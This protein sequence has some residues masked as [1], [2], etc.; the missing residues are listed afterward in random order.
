M[1]FKVILCDSN[2]TLTIFHG[3]LKT[4]LEHLCN[5]GHHFVNVPFTIYLDTKELLALLSHQDALLSLQER[6]EHKTLYFLEQTL[7]MGG[8]S[9]SRWTFS[10]ELRCSWKDESEV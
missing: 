1:V 6:Q 5:W 10:E 3:L 8:G 7:Q 9:R 2:I 4:R